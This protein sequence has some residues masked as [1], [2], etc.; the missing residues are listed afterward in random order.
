MHERRNFGLDA[1]RATA[2]GLVLLSHFVTDLDFLGY[3]G[4]DLFF[5]LSGFLIGGILLK[6]LNTRGAFDFADLRE[7]LKRR[8]YRTLPNYYLF[9]VIYL[10][11]NAVFLY[12]AWPH[13]RQIATNAVFLQNFAWPNPNWLFGHS[14]SL[15][16]EEWFYLLTATTLF[17]TTK[18]FPASPGGRTWAVGLTI[19]IFI[20]GPAGLRF[21]IGD[22]FEFPQL[23][24][25][26][27]LDAIMFGVFVALV[28]SRFPSVWNRPFTLL[29][30]GAIAATL[31]VFLSSRQSPT[32]TALALTLLPLGFAGLLPAVFRI[33]VPDN[34]VARWVEAIST[35]SYSMYLCH[36]LIYQGL[37][38]I[39]GYDNLGQLEKLL[40][41]VV[42][43]ALIILL[44]AMVYR[45]FEKPVTD[46]RDRFQLSRPKAGRSPNPSM[47]TAT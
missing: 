17:L 31:G 33:P 30:T 16:V 18:L 20:M 41:K 35:W 11:F 22:Q 46:L 38:P 24:V 14:W 40:Y 13:F 42:A 7:F 47:E 10:G 3:Y 36:T 21:W 32:A 44:S 9:L 26:F 4:V 37:K 34:F 15:C 6:M 25:V 39:V 29:A 28:R 2:I 1:M 43:L 12:H 8:W 27:R 5:V 23:V 45:F 19:A